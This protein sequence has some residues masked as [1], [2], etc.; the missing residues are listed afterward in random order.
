VRIRLPVMPVRRPGG[1]PYP[2]FAPV[3]RSLPALLAAGV[4]LLVLLL[5]P[6]AAADI[7]R[8][9]DGEGAV[10][11]TDD[12][13]TIPPPYRGKATLHIREAPGSRLPLPPAEAP[14]GPATGRPG[15]PPPQEENEGA[16]LAR[17]REE[18]IS[19]IDQLDAKIAAKESHIQAVDR[20][21]SLAVNPLGNKFVD[22]P[23]LELYDKYQAELPADLD[24]LRRLEEDLARIR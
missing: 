14:R 16:R 19:R 3:C 7:Y 15:P 10:H 18:L 6:S 8:W 11:F 22:P 23:D 9:E 13:S 17:E 1:R 20:K 4:L 21:R 24:E 5:P 12:I 2:R